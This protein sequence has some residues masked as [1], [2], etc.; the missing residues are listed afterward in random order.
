MNNDRCGTA[1]LLYAPPRREKP[2]EGSPGRASIGWLP[3]FPN[4]SS[5]WSCA[6]AAWVKSHRLEAPEVLRSDGAAS[7]E[8][9]TVDSAHSRRGV[10]CVEC[11]PLA[12]PLAKPTPGGSVHGVHDSLV[13]PARDRPVVP[14]GQ[15][16]S[17][18]ALVRGAAGR[19][20]SPS[21]RR[22]RK[23]QAVSSSSASSI[24]ASSDEAF[25]RGP[26]SM[27]PPVWR[28]PSHVFGCPPANGEVPTTTTLAR[29]PR[30]LGENPSGRGQRVVQAVKKGEVACRWSSRR[31]LQGPEIPPGASPNLPVDE[32]PRFAPQGP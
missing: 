27:C 4:G 22:T 3:P 5:S 29:L 1:P 16:G 32:N 28:P 2:P 18:A 15:L 11:T 8:N 24:F 19:W 13:T 20:R 10:P 21:V 12:G 31:G 17:P 23:V 6:T 26:A 7:R 25:A 9:D 30:A 14:R